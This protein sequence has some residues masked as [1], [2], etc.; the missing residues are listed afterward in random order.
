MVLFTL[1]HTLNVSICQITNPIASLFLCD[2][3]LCR[4]WMYYVNCSA[5]LHV[6]S[7]SS[8]MGRYTEES[9]FKPIV[10]AHTWMAW[11]WSTRTAFF[12]G[13]LLCKRVY[14][15]KTFHYVHDTDDNLTCKATFMYSC[16]LQLS[17][18]CTH[19]NY[20]VVKVMNRFLIVANKVVKV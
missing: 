19:D 6:V 18:I 20:S 3:N 10:H 8:S 1:S 2:T 14:S 12:P 4:S 13:A 17:T 11:R 15:Y 16:F 9:A 7:K 5:C